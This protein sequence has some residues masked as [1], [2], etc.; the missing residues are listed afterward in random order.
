[1]F[2]HQVNL[3]S[4]LNTATR[5]LKIA[6]SLDANILVS[7]LNSYADFHS[8]SIQLIDINHLSSILKPLKPPGDTIELKIQR[9]GKEPRQGVGYLDDGTM[10]VVNNGGDFI[11]QLINTQVISVKQTSSGRIVFTNAILAESVEN[12]D[13]SADPLYENIKS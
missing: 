8:S 7:S 4:N 6:K 3:S 2:N 12:K 5:T 1:M 9:S 10:V 11:G 13:F